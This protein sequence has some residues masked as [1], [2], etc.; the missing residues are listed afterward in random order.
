MSREIPGPLLVMGGSSALGLEFLR[1][2]ASPGRLVLAGCR[3]GK[4]RLEALALETGARIEPLEADLATE[5]GVLDFLGEVEAHTDCPEHIVHLPAGKLELARFKD[6]SWTGFQAQ[7][8]LQVRSAAMVLHRFLPRMAKRGSGRVAV[9]LSSVTLGM[10]P[11]AMAPYV[12]AKHALLGLVRA[13]ASEYAGRGVTVNAVS[14]GMMQTPMLD[15]VPEKVLEFAAAHNPMRRIARPA[16]VAPVLAFLLSSEAGYL[17][18]ANI[19]V[20][21]GAGV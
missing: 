12:V 13:L 1:L 9:A 3:T 16:D 20:T 18:G 11:A 8:D 19:P 5:D 21:G 17:T 7:L 2:V 15:G 4:A 14:P 6:L 10:P